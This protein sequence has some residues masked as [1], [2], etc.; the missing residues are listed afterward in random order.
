MED[1]PMKRWTFLL[2]LGAVACAPEEPAERPIEPNLVEVEQ[3]LLPPVN[4]P[5]PACPIPGP[6]CIERVD[7][8]PAGSPDA[9]PG[10]RW[11]GRLPQNLN[12]AQACPQP[13]ED[14]GDGGVWVTAKLFST[15]TDLRPGEVAPAIPG[16]LGRY[17]L[18]VWSPLN[19]E[20]PAPPPDLT[21]NPRLAV[22]AGALDTD[23]AVTAGV[24]T[25][26]T[27][28]VADTL[29]SSYYA[30]IGRLQP[31]PLRSVNGVSTS[32]DEIRVG[33]VDSTPR[34]PDDGE[35][36]VGTDDHGFGV[37]RIVRELACPLYPNL[38]EVCVG[39]A[40]NHLALPRRTLAVA[41]RDDGGYF[42]FFGEVATAIFG[43]VGA[44]DRHNALGGVQQPR[45]VI[46]LSL[47]WD[48][49]WGGEVG[50]TA[51]PMTPP[52][53]AVYDAIYAAHCRGALIIAA[54]GN[55]IDGPNPTQGPMYPGGWEQ[56]P[57]PSKAECESF[58]GGPINE[59]PY[60]I[61]KNTPAYRPLL[62]AV[63]GVR[64]DD[65]PL[66]NAR[67]G[68]TP[69]L[70]APA[71]MAVSTLGGSQTDALTG[72][73]VAAA[74]VSG[75]AA[76]LWGYRA[77]L[78]AHEVMDRIYTN[79]VSLSPSAVGGIGRAEF[80][81]APNVCNTLNVKRLDAC[82]ALKA[83]CAGGA[84][85]CPTV[86]VVCAAKRLK[87]KGKMPSLAPVQPAL[88]A[89]QGSA[90]TDPTG[91]CTFDA[92]T[93]GTVVQA[94]PANCTREA[95][96]ILLRGPGEAG[97]WPDDPCPR[98]QFPNG[99][100]LPAAGPQPGVD[101][102]P[103]CSLS[104]NG[105]T[106]KWTANLAISLDYAGT[107]LTN[108]TLQVKSNSKTVLATY[109]LTDLGFPTNMTAGSVYKVTSINIGTT[110][111]YATVTWTASNGGTPWTASSE[112]L[113][114]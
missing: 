5:A 1:N 53:R 90:C 98:V 24:S 44:W 87:F 58:L 16:E 22:L 74:A 12:P 25:P 20:D 21:D 6:A 70:V 33:V 101:P 77:R 64:P 93:L 81:M 63:G 26:Y 55:T 17:C 72:S 36:D 113:I 11:I 80:C 82:A 79:A 106:K 15:D 47:G 43:S 28:V 56:V 61:F 75:T 108:G 19:V 110:F 78:T 102:C 99:S 31:L 52:V 88:D 32:P 4:D 104:L 92:T 69:R 66:D 10:T 49:T 41:D 89:L 59:V 18:Y 86:P 45:L 111:S 42:G 34:G 65:R 95:T 105:L 50:G 60:K 14:D 39:Q 13:S 62:Y 96:A 48:S 57:G 46:N 23:C 68:G 2:S 3:A 29:A 51:T 97:A 114:Y 38:G 107:S 73:S 76:T 84:E 27:A 83:T 9:C 71:F 8:P 85:K 7:A 112:L 54:A 109:K 67:E 91:V 30:Q 103:D 35:A 100:A 37:G 94:N 40:S